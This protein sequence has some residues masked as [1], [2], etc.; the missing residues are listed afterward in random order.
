MT[1]D[2]FGNAAILEAY[3]ETA[4]PGWKR[5]LAS[6][7]ACAAEVDEIRGIRKLYSQVRPVRLNIRVKRSILSRLRREGRRSR[8]RAALTTL[9]AVGA[10][11]F[12][13]AGIGGA[14][15]MVAAAEPLPA[16]STID[17]AIVEVRARVTDLETEGPS[18]F[19]ST[20]DDLKARVGS[21]TWDAENM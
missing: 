11:F 20:L 1:C 15:G 2:R 8:M 4:A 3:G 19:D 6:C 10:A 17:M 21:L 9:A 12:L 7:D 14:P 16:D 13:V 18:V 5:H